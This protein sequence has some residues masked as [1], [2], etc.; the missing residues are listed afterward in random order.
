MALRFDII[1]INFERAA[2]E[3]K[4]EKME[5]LYSYITSVEFRHRIEG[6]VEAFNS[7][8]EELEREKRWFNTKWARQDKQIRRVLDH[9][10]GMYGDLQALVGKPLPEIKS[11]ELDSGD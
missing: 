10:H 11:L 2:T 9:T 8:Q 7:Q 4:S 5:V 1:R 3:G 6:I